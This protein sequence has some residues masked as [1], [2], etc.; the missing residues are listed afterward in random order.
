MF[1]ISGQSNRQQMFPSCIPQLL[2]ITLFICLTQFAMANGKIKMLV[3]SPASQLN[4]KNYTWHLELAKIFAKDQNVESVVR[5]III[6]ICSIPKYEYIPICS[7]FWAW[8]NR[9]MRKSQKKL[10]EN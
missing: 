8:S 2:L 10:K 4:D 9:R 1:F 6:K 3:I 7:S 5:I